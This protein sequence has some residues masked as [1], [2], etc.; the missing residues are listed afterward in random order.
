MEPQACISH[1][2]GVGA[3][4]TDQ[5]SQTPCAREARSLGGAARN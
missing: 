3:Q 2:Q 1:L 4:F 5:A